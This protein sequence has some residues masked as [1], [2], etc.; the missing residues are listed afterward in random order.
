MFVRSV[1]PGFVGL[2]S[3]WIF[4]V[5]VGHFGLILKVG[6]FGMETKTDLYR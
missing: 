1:Q 3:R 2:T 5:H 4:A 6:H